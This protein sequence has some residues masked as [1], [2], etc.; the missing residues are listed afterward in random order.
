MSPRGA[1]SEPLQRSHA[2]CR[3]AIF[4][5][6]WK[7]LGSLEGGVGTVRAGRGSLVRTGIT[8]A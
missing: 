5:R 6:L 8:Q 3:D 1:A 7:T 2:G 4:R